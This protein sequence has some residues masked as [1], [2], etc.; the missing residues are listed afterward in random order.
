MEQ[1]KVE[2]AQH[3]AGDVLWLISFSSRSANPYNAPDPLQPMW[4]GTKY[5]Y[6]HTLIELP[7]GYA[8]A[9][10]HGQLGCAKHFILRNNFEKLRWSNTKFS[11]RKLHYTL[12]VLRHTGTC[13]HLL[14]YYVTRQPKAVPTKSAS[15]VA[16]G[17]DEFNKLRMI[18]ASL[19]RNNTT[20]PDKQTPPRQVASFQYTNVQSMFRLQCFHILHTIYI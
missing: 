1:K 4:S 14:F 19:C 6:W 10:G 11:A 16:V 3:Y 15:R 20:Q 13:R 8:E 7:T 18:R 12:L 5:Q 17:G 2:S 9:L